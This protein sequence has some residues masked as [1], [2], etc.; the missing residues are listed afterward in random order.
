LD[1]LSGWYRDGRLQGVKWLGLSR[2]SDTLSKIN[3][4]FDKFCVIVQDL[5]NLGDGSIKSDENCSIVLD[6]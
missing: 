6:Y 4:I 3:P 2:A 5:E 1:W